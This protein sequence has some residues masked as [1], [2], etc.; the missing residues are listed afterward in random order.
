[1][2]SFEVLCV[3]MNQSDFSKV[4]EMNIH[5][6]VVFA[7]QSDKNCYDEFE[8]DGNRAK[9][10]T[11]STRGVGINRNFALCYANSDICLFA[12]DDVKYVDNMEELIVNEFEANP[13]ADIIIF[14]LDTNDSVRRQK[15][16]YKTKPHR[17]WE[18]M[19]WATFRIAVRTK[20]VRKANLWFTT[21]FGGGCVFP[22]GEDSMWLTDAKKKGLK[23]YVSKEVIGTVDF[24]VSTWY[25][26]ANEKFYYGKGAFYK[27]IHPRMLYVWMMYFALRTHKVSELSFLQRIKWMLTGAKQ[28]ENLN[29]YESYI[30]SIK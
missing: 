27:C 7:N 1:M 20:S 3:T 2:L 13:D 12:D 11:T 22:S 28:Y 14:N 6:N 26:G 10:I 4:K 15:R 29:S 24:S 5:S 25:S 30:K 17:F 9:M 21:L 16:Y 23:F 19:P 8:F 18:R